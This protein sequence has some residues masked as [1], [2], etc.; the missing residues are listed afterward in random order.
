MIDLP[1]SLFAFFVPFAA[2]KPFPKTIAGK[3]PRSGE[4]I[5][6][7]SS[8]P[9]AIF[10]ISRS[11]SFL[12]LPV[13]LLAWPVRPAT[14]FDEEPAGNPPW[15]IEA[16]NLTYIR[17]PP[18]VMATGNVILR[19]PESGPDGGVIYPLEVRAGRIRYNI[20]TETVE[21]SG[22]LTIRTPEDEITASEGF[23]DLKAQTGSFETSTLF[24]KENNFY[25]SGGTIS[26][27]GPLTYHLR[28]ATATTCPMPATGGAPPWSFHSR[29]ARVTREGYAL[30]RHVSFR[31]RDYPVL[32]SP[33]LLL[34]AKTIRQTG[35]LFPEYSQ[36]SRNGTGLVAPFFVN[37]S[38][39]ADLTFYPGFLSE[40]GIPV[41]GEFRYFLEEYS[42]GTLAIDYLRDRL[43][44]SPAN[45]FKSDAIPRTNA[46]RYWL[47]GKADHDF[48]ANLFARLDVDI[49]SDRDYLQEFN[50]G[51]TG[52]RQ[53]NAAFREDF[54]R[55]FQPETVEQRDNSLLMAKSWP[56][57][58]LSGQL[59]AVNDVGEIDTGVSP[60]WAL[61]RVDFSGYRP[62]P[63][64][65]PL[66][67]SWGS[68]YVYYRRD[69]GVA[70]H[71]LDLHPRLLTSLPFGPRVENSLTAGL[72][73]TL[74]RAEGNE[75]AATSPINLAASRTLLDF[76]ATLATTLARNFG[77]GRA[78]AG[79]G[80]GGWRLH[81]LMRPELAYIF[82]ADRDQ[83]NLPRLDEI[84][85]I[86]SRRWVKYSLNN[87]FSLGPQSA[88][89]SLGGPDAGSLKISQAY[90]TEAGEHPWA[91]LFVELAAHPAT[92]WRLAY[93]TAMSVNGQGVPYYE[94]RLGYT[95]PR[96]GRIGTD[97]RYKR[98]PEVAE[99][100]FFS[101]IAGASLHTIHGWLAAPLTERLTI[102][103][104][105]THSLSSGEVVE[106]SLSLNYQAGCWSVGLLG[107]TAPDE[108][109][110]ALVLS[111]SGIGKALELGLPG[112]E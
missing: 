73:E 39:G 94:L 42:R 101:E 65:G 83:A 19:R 12:L 75:T 24:H 98:Q 18:A 1:G 33:I 78:A 43:I 72:R 44:D 99:P 56:S 16:D 80:T 23:L 27:T 57:V 81:H 48:G 46:D 87:L 21:A 97:Y 5:G 111:L 58:Y 106:S 50:T 25:L 96:R 41:G 63:G 2:K 55:G 85:R 79:G 60:L 40:R 108:T 92:G 45:D 100:F 82:V 67:L 89:A 4:A 91:D 34:P 84:D 107:N 38:P 26:K 3:F 112:F 104:D 93:E 86:E 105:L 69:R 71:R 31:V 76:D 14:A 54:Q 22:N 110:V 102:G 90:D 103:G 32:Y 10:S 28:Q 61:P 53:S 109:R 68:E 13:L 30:L 37:L 29:E 74:Y 36:S 35:L 49:V 8:P 11:T 52:F 17:E 20:A 47:R 7:E 70:G 15:E 59:L 6:C 88:G 66:D 95:G 9:R 77:P 62:L 64:A 51:L